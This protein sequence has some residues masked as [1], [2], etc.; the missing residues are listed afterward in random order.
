[1]ND[2]ML[3]LESAI[4]RVESNINAL[5]DKMG[6]MSTAVRTMSQ[7][8]SKL[9]VTD[10]K[11]ERL[12]RDIQSIG[13]YSRRSTEALEDS[14]NK[15]NSKIDRLNEQHHKTRE[16]RLQEVEESTNERGISR[17]KLM[18]W[19]VFGSLSFLTTI[20]F[21]YGDDISKKIDTVID[22][23]T[24]V[25]IKQETHDGKFKLLEEKLKNANGHR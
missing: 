6:D 5:T 20:A 23:T 9:A 16:Q 13:D 7:A 21:M 15:L 22:T 14:V 4:I 12:E 25:K 19:M 1:M 24:K 18:L 2:K 10:V 3:E 11:V 17:F 8:V